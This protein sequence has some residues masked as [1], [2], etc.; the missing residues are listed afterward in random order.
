MPN[1]ITGDPI[2]VAAALIENKRE[3]VLTLVIGPMGLVDDESGAM[4]IFGGDGS[5]L[6]GGIGCP[7]AEPTLARAVVECFRRQSPMVVDI[8][9]NEHVFDDCIPCGG[10]L[11]VYVEAVVPIR[12]VADE[13]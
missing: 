1:N 11:R 8:E 6:A 10:S 2:G 5:V 9:L 12:A 4:A 13:H 3:F 7:C